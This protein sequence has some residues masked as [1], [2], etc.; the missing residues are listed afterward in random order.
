M[1]FLA[2][3]PGAILAGSALTA[4]A[5]LIGD[6][7]NG[8]Q[9]N[10]QDVYTPGPNAGIEQTNA[11]QWAN[12]LTQMGNS[13]DYGA[14]QPDWND[15]WN[16][17]QQQVQNY[18]SGTATQP[19]VNDQISASFAQ[20]GMSGDPAASYLQAASGANEAQDLGNLSAQQNIAQNQFGLE[21]QQQYLN[22][23]AQFQQAINPT[24]GTWT[25]AQPYATTGQQIG[26]AI[27]AVGSGAVQYGIGQANN[28]SQTAYL[29]S[30]LNPTSTAGFSSPT[31]FSTS[32]EQS[33]V[34]AGVT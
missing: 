7:M 30:V 34:L 9:P 18:F 10:I 2:T 19:G 15:I 3:I 5:G 13:P 24:A 22:S 12:Q 32:L 8:G 21:G 4:G 14:I 17:T 11:N 28:A 29:N 1:P 6:S 25:G 31:G 23:M 26:N 27:G 16:Q 33:P 20:R